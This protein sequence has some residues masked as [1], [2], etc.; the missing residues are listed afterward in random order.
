MPCPEPY[1]VR[2][3]FLATHQFIIFI[4][5]IEKFWKSFAYSKNFKII[6]VSVILSFDS[7]K[8]ILFYNKFS[9][10]SNRIIQ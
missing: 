9:N 8:N 3:R 6:F 2:K 5:Q 1:P 10:L 4:K 7:A